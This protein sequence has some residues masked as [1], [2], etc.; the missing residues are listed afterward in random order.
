MWG[1]GPKTA[2]RFHALGVRTIG[3]LRA[4]TEERLV[5]EFGAASAEHFGT[6][7]RGDDLRDVVPDAQSKSIGHE[8]TF[9]VDVESPDD[10]REVLLQQADAVGRR[11]RRHGVR[12]RGVTVK[13]RYGEFET[14]T[15]AATL[16]EPT[17][18]D[19]DLRRAAAAIFDRWAK[20]SFR[21]VRLIGVTAG[22]LTEE[23]P[24]LPLF[25]AA[26]AERKRRL[27]RALDT[28]KDRFGGGVIRR[29]RGER[30]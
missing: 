17:D 3:Q 7:S 19:L 5:R 12:A 28:I 26:D 30:G 8:Q 25:G 13:I 27:D 10:V 9:E 29:G 14:I 22:R 15:R 20:S 18:A 23:G 21:P 11:V 6:L 2:E 16:D 1:V 4:W 24:Q